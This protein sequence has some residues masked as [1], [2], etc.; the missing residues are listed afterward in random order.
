MDNIEYQN[1]DSGLIIDTVFILSNRI[2][3]RFP[4][5]GIYHVSLN[6][7]RFPVEKITGYST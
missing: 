2:Y 4:D 5:S 1:L 7:M 3:E 6:S